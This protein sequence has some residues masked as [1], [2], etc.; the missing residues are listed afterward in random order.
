MWSRPWMMRLI[1]YYVQL[2]T[3]DIH[4]KNYERWNKCKKYGV[5]NVYIICT[6]KTI[7]KNLIKPLKI[8]YE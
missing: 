2:D 6:D 1:I 5:M 8:M 3:Q 4:D 7:L